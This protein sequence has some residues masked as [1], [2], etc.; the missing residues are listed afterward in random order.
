MD[1]DTTLTNTGVFAAIGA[2]HLPPGPLMVAEASASAQ[3]LE[4]D[5]ASETLIQ[6]FN[7]TR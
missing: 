3:M 2:P 6:E 4:Q 7:P 1:D 5:R